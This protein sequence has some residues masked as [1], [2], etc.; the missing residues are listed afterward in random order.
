M[1]KL[2]TLTDEELLKFVNSAFA[3]TING[4]YKEKYLTKSKADEIIGNYSIVVESNRWLPKS[5]AKWLGLKE[6][7]IVFRLVRA[8][9][10]R[11]N[12]EDED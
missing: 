5:V 12:E 9:D 1:S 11:A 6:D 7:R 8:V 3:N 2:Y 10:R 4:L